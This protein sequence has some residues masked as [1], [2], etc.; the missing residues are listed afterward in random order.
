MIVC[1]R[2]KLLPIT[3][4]SHRGENHINARIKKDIF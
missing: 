2:H 4:P 3:L 1:D